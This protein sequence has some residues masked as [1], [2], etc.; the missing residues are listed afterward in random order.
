[1]RAKDGLELAVGRD[2]EGTAP[3]DG[4]G[5][6]STGRVGLSD[7]GGS[8][9]GAGGD[10]FDDGPG[11]SVE[12]GTVEELGS[13]EARFGRAVRPRRRVGVLEPPGTAGDEGVGDARTGREG[14]VGAGESEC[15]GDGA[16]ARDALD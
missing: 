2:V 13:G 5:D 1:M 9:G 15:G 16:G 10:D 4:M 8:C 7:S 14:L 3:V 11:E 12:A 6:A